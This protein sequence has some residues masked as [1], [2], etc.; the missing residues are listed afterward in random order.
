MGTFYSLAFDSTKEGTL[1]HKLVVDSDIPNDSQVVIS[2]YVSDSRA[3]SV[4]EPDIDEL[5]RRKDRDNLETINWTTL[6]TNP[7]DA[8]INTGRGRYL[9]LKIQLIANDRFTP[10]IK[11]FVS[12]FPLHLIWIIYLRCIVKMRRV[13]SFWRDFWHFSRP[14][15]FQQRIR[16]IIFPVIL[17]WTPYRRVSSMDGSMAVNIL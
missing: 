9:W 10:V 14:S 8:L 7:K 15:S 3:F 1:W 17:M 13:K 12:I 2:Y 16:L 6:R 4:D 11:V 5:V